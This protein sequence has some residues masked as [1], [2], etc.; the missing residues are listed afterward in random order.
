MSITKENNSIKTKKDKKENQYFKE[1][2]MDYKRICATVATLAPLAIGAAK[3]M[4]YA[5]QSGR[6]SVYDI[7]NV[8]ME[9]NSE[10]IL[11][12]IVRLIAVIIVWF[13]INYLYYVIASTADDSKF[14]W[15]RKIR[16]LFFWTIELICLFI[17]IL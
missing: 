6:F 2:K 16:I 7:A 14:H 5:Y 9:Q 12:Q 10:S 15:K 11:F 17:V 8:Y 4:W 1:V 3:A 13:S